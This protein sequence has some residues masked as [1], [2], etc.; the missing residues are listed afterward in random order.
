MTRSR[1]AAIHRTA[2][3]PVMRRASSRLVCTVTSARTRPCNRRRCGCCGR[4]PD[5]C[6]T[7]CRPVAADI[8]CRSASG[9]LRQQDQQVDV[10][11]GKQFAASIAAHCHQRQSRR[12]ASILPH[13][14]QMFVDQLAC[15]CSWRLR[16]RMC[17]EILLQRF[18][19]R[20][21]TVADFSRV[22][23]RS[24][25]SGGGGEPAERVSTSKPVSV[26]RM[27]CSHCADRL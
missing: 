1:L 22:F 25:F 19:C 23:A 26:T 2:R 18:S 3:S 27:V 5:R 21:Q 16:L 6:P 9:C 15:A 12:H 20:A 24:Q 8:C 17:H 10:G 11:F 4:L 7:T 13:H 14:A